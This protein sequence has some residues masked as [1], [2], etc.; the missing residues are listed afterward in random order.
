M[1]LTLL[2]LLLTAAAS[3]QTERPKD[4]EG[5][6]KITWKMTLADVR[7]IYPDA[8]P[9]DDPYWS[10]LALPAIQVADIPLQVTVSAKKPSA[11]VGL[12][13]LWCH[14]GVPGNAGE[15]A[16]PNVTRAGFETLK[17]LM[18]QKYGHQKNEEHKTDYGD[19]ETL[20]LWTFPSSS[21]E[22]KLRLTRGTPSMG[23][24]HIE[25][26]PLDPKSLDIL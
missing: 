18:I 13:A 20:F 21:I 3:A 16:P 7:A 19:P 5:W 9:S 14:F 1:K 26:R 2:A 6:Q 24:L 12:I 10:H 25:F 11:Q 8:K 23:S 22:L 17:A 15:S 4:V